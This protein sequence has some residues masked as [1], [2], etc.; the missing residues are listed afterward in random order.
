MR[1]T[2]PSSAPRRGV[3]RSLR[4]ANYR[5]WVVGALVSNIG[6]W[7][8]R[9]GQEW[10][11]LTELTDHSA[12]ALGLVMALQFGPQ[13]LLLPLTGWAA[14]RFDQRR[15]LAVTQG[16]MGALA[17]ALGILAVT[18]L[19]QLWHV[20]VF[21]FLFGCAAALDAPV[22]QT[23][24]AE[25]VGDADLSNAIALNSTSFNLARMV[26]P[27]AAGLVIAGLGT[28]WAFLINALS[29]LA[30]LTSLGFIRASELRTRLRTSDPPGSL[31][32]GWRHVWSRPDLRATM[33]ML[34]LIG[35]LGLNFPIFI[36]TMAVTVF[37]ADARAFGLLSTVMALGTVAGALL[38]A[39]RDT[40]LF[41]TLG[42]GAAVFGVGCTMAALAPTYWVF[43]ASL[44]VIGAAAL[45]VTNTA[46]SLTQ[47]AT[48]SSLRGRVVA[49]RVG[50]VL[51]GT[52]VGAPLVGWV[53]DRFGPRWSL[54]VGAAAGFA[55][56]IVAAYRLVRRS[57]PA[58]RS[59]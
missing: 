28:G 23:F 14:D 26:G 10:I 8:Q 3:F 16:T 58:D 37:H 38:A 51:G 59:R 9:V 1:G 33:I 39:G 54:G 5:I 32:E 34:L 18:G 25:L 36:S 57:E 40:P 7:M 53:A 56:A 17:L 29:F 19:V 22:R 43:A 27:A 31:A 2:E 15:L 6:T 55:A 44:A 46:S 20:H 4:S 47:L 50:I 41:S 49:I 21:A 52:P 42:A 24:V 11:V 13:L 48:P 45:T 35:T 12:S 30:V